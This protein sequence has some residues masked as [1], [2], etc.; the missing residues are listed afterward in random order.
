MLTKHDPS[1]T[2]SA[3]VSGSRLLN[4]AEPHGIAGPMKPALAYRPDIDGLR[5]VA[6]LA[7]LFYHLHIWPFGGGFV[8]VDVFF[9]ISGYLITGII[10]SETAALTFS[11]AD[12]YERRARR[13]GPALIAVIAASFVVAALIFEPGDLRRASIATITALLGVSNISFWTESGYF[14]VTAVLKPLLHTWSLAVELQFYL[15]WP[16]L[17]VIL[18]RRGW[19]ATISGIAIAIVAATAVSLWVLPRDAAAAFYLAPF[20]IHEFAIGAL[21]VAIEGKLARSGWWPDLAFLG[22][23]ALVIASVVLFSDQTSFPGYLVLIPTL[24]AALVLLG[25]PQARS[26]LLLR[27]GVA[28]SLGKISYSLYLIHWPLIVFARYRLDLT[29]LDWRHQSILLATSLVLATAS[30]H[31]VERPFRK[32]RASA[33]RSRAPFYMGCAA[34]TLLVA[35]PATHAVSTRGWPWRFPGDIQAINAIDIPEQQQY[36]WENFNRLSAASFTTGKRRVLI[37]GD[38]QAADLVNM[39]VAAGFERH[40][41]IITRTIAWECGLPYV[42]GSYGDD[43]WKTRN[44]LTI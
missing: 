36:V 30:Y 9:V 3:G 33:G 26:A 43:F 29:E 19:R 4:E 2:S 22:G 10:L 31:F 6:V 11:F 7:V 35:I 25:A 5:A 39:L 24:G 17:I 16:L 18:Q 14:D 21:V 40:N 28:V 1:R 15:V 41:E 34:V 20:R 27:N 38:S 23:L 12:F 8:G 37:V 13:L 42:D 32:R 44:D